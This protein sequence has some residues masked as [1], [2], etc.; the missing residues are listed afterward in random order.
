M[1]IN[2]TLPKHTEEEA[3]IVRRLGW[4][5][6]EQWAALPDD[7]KERILT[8]AVFVRD[9]YQTV[10]LKEQIDAFMRKYAES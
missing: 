9:L 1:D 7:A 2:G 8:Q 10:Q 3:H 6:V 4:A 5:V